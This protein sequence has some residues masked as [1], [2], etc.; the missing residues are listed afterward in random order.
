MKYTI[1]LSNKEVYTVDEEDYNKITE[2][3]NEPLVKLKVGIINPAFV[4][5][6]KPDQETLRE[7][8]REKRNEE[9][10]RL[11]SKP[12]LVE[13]DEVRSYRPDFIKE[14]LSQKGNLTNPN[15]QI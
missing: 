10:L 6:M 11:I 12:N 2:N 15:P 8:V 1:S 5:S 9:T 7:E 13:V 3:I 14:A 4:I